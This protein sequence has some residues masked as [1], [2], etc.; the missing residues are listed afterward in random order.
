MLSSSNV[1][2][3]FK[4][5]PSKQTRKEGSNPAVIAY[6]LSEKIKIE[7]T[8]RILQDFHEYDLVKLPDDLQDEALL[9]QA[10]GSNGNEINDN[11]F[12]FQEGSVVFWD[13]SHEQQ[14]R[15]LYG[16]AN[17]KEE[18]YPRELIHEE[19]ERL[20]FTINKS[21]EK[22]KMQRDIVQLALNQ[23]TLDVQLDQ[24]AVSHAISL[25]VKL[26]IWES[27]L[28]RYVDSIGWV[29]KSMKEGR[30]LGLTRDQIFKKT[31]EIYELKHR[32]NLNSD[33]LDLPDVYWD[34]HE[35]E[36]LFLSVL[37]FLNI[38]RR[39]SVIN[40]KLNNCCELMNL[41]TNHMNDKHHVRLEWMIIVLIMVE[42]LFEVVRFI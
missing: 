39:T 33:L 20:E 17:L 8:K 19:R 37:S 31:G 14:Q 2:A 40:D 35:Q 27:L 13:V 25:S 12:I 22:S 5:Y 32:I 7:K 26:A 6:T 11:V 15:I 42:V 1:V 29:T 38:N 24:F 10:K 41:L 36:V 16:L 9:L 3:G 30:G 18:P 23:S 34:R 28:D 4:R 21:S